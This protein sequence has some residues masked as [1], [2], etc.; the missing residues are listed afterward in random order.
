MYD[1]PRDL[2]AMQCAGYGSNVD[3]CHLEGA[4]MG[5]HEGCADR[6]FRVFGVILWSLSGLYGCQACAERAYASRLACWCKRN[7]R[8]KL[9]LH[10]TKRLGTVWGEFAQ[11]V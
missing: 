11:C 3:R 8:V 1:V 10:L 6:L 7:D 9:F 2:S 4:R 5:V